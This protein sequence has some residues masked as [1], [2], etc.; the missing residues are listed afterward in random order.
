MKIFAV[1]IAVFAVS[2]QPA[3]AAE[4]PKSEAAYSAQR[5]MEGDGAEASGQINHDR[6]KERWE[7]NMGGTSVVRIM[8]LDL[9]KLLMYMP[10]INMAMEMPLPGNGQFGP[11]AGSDGP[12]SEAIGKEQ[13]GGENTT[14]YRTEVDDPQDG[15]FVVTSWVTDDGIVMRTEGQG[16]QGSFAMYLE[17]LQRGPQDATLFELPPGVTLM[18]VNPAM[19]EQFK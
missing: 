7:S 15:L 16:T 5:V 10:D 8:R 9:G 11:P 18:P 14:V 12:A 4:W 6:G 3:M 17:G 2:M 19:L 1:I 13:M